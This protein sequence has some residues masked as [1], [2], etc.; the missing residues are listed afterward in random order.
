MNKL[1]V[2]LE[3]SEM[4][5]LVSAISMEALFY[6]KGNQMYLLNMQGHLN[7][8]KLVNG[9]NTVY[10]PFDWKPKQIHVNDLNKVIGADGKINWL[11][12]KITD[13]P[14]FKGESE[15]G[16]EM[17]FKDNKTTVMGS[18]FHGA[19]F[20]SYHLTHTHSNLDPKPTAVE[21]MDNTLSKHVRLAN[22]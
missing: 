15:W 11:S 14:D 3:K 8:K 22:G 1:T 4:S 20:Q 19:D 21:L 5:P 10:M 7:I 18:G 16:V 13:I 12:P 2:R 6:V 9:I 17:L